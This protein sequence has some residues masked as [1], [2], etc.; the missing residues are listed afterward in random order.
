[1][2]PEKKVLDEA[3]WRT[4]VSPSSRSSMKALVA[5]FVGGGVGVLVAAAAATLA[6]G[7][8]GVW[9]TAALWVGMAAAVVHSLFV[10]RARGLFKLQPADLVWG[11]GGAILLRLLAG[12][13]SSADSHPFPTV[14]SAITPLSSWALREVL[15][16]GLIGPVVEELFFRAVLVVATYRLLR[17][18]LGSPSA[19]AVS[20]VASAGAFVLLHA[21]FTPLV[22]AD[23]LQLFALGIACSLLVL[24]TGRVWGAL[25]LH[26][27]YNGSFLL[28]AFVG[29]VL[30]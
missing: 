10:L 26:V 14:D 23:S 11:L 9:S 4:G 8:P 22:L 5:V 30:T 15:P 28:L 29:S 3:D 16:A 13:I 27:T 6:D 1:M 24:L 7:D 17:L 12:V 25:L 18:Y 20:T 21:A 2:V 19:G